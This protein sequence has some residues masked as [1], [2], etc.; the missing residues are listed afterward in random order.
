MKPKKQI[1]EYYDF[2][3]LQKIVN[4]SLGYDQS[5]RANALKQNNEN[6]RYLDF[7]DWQDDYCFMSEFV[8]DSFNKLYVGLDLEQPVEKWIM[9]IQQKYNELFEE[10]ADEEGYVKIKIC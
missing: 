9:E 3:E 8:N 6:D 4:D 10:I 7:F 5:S 2:F 1:L